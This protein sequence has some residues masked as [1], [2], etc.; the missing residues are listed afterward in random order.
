LLM[1]THGII[2]ME[3]SSGPF[4]PTVVPEGH[5]ITSRAAGTAVGPTPLGINS[6]VFRLV[7]KTDASLVAFTPKDLEK[8][9]K[10]Y[11]STAA[12]LYRNA[13][14]ALAAEY[15]WSAAENVA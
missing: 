12:A 10:V 3:S 4:V 1:I 7:A 9:H 5:R 2:D 13:A 15:R 6:K 11:P 14:V 8:L